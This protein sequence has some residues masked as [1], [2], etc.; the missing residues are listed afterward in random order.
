MVNSRGTFL[1]C[2]CIIFG[3][4]TLLLVCL[5]FG[6]SNVC[7]VV[8]LTFDKNAV[9][10]RIDCFGGFLLL[11]SN[12]SDFLKQLS[13]LPLIPFSI[14]LISDIVVFTSKSLIGSFSGIFYVST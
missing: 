1:L 11:S 13:N 3:H 4:L 6:F 8:K 10:S 5:E 12:L 14:F 9:H 2:L 7:K